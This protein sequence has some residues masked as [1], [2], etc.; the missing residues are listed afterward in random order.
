MPGALG[1]VVRPVQSQALLHA[2]RLHASDCLALNLL[3][4]RQVFKRVDTGKREEEYQLAGSFEKEPGAA[5]ITPLFRP[6]PTAP[7]WKRYW[8]Q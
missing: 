5:E 6:K 1:G 8:Q 7:T 3:D 4:L 2:P